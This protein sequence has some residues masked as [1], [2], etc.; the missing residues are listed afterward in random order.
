MLRIEQLGK[1][2]KA[3]GHAVRALHNINLDIQKGQI[4]GIIGRSGAGKSS[5]LRTLNL[6]ERPS[7]GKVWIEGEDITAFDRQRLHGLR[8]RIGM[9]FQHFNLL[10]AKTVTENI[11][12]P[13]KLTGEYTSDTIQAR[14][15]ELLELVGLKDQGR[16]YPAQLSGGQKQRVGIARALANYPQLLLCDEATS[17]LDPETTQAILRLLLD[18][19]QKLGLTIVLI[20]HEMQ[21]IR[22]I[23]DE[24]AV[25]DAGEIVETGA[26][27]DVFLHPQHA[28]TQSLVAENQALDLSVLERKDQDLD[29]HL[30]RLSYVGSSTH[31]PIITRIA[32]QTGIDIA[33]L[34]GV[35]GR[36]KNTPYGQLLVELRSTQE[37]SDRVEQL[38]VNAG[39]RV[40]R[41]S[42]SAAVEVH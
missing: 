5:L 4:F 36:I 10:H 13:L 23:C 14:V 38:L 42:I 9:V 18:I 1:Y 7:S 33:I 24:V 15:E 28:V 19:N 2:Y 8:Q 21:V 27:V 6:L 30:L 35:I 31:E 22:T 16:K 11:A 26:V 34:Q 29:R 12:F 40:A 3:N 32:V 37:Q 17:A 20:T 39:V 41:I 25:I